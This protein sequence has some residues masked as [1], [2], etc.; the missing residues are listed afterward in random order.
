MKSRRYFAVVVDRFGFVINSLHKFSKHVTSYVSLCIRTHIHITAHCSF[1]E[2]GSLASAG[3]TR[4]A[5]E[6]VPVHS[7]PVYG[8]S[9]QDFGQR[10]IS[11]GRTR[12]EYVCQRTEG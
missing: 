11:R 6:K 5:S 10:R 7:R 2:D 12:P 1:E 3:H 9:G 8:A 4:G